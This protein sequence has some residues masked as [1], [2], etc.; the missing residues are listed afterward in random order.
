MW[1][2]DDITLA[3]WIF[4]TSL[5]DTTVGV[6][7]KFAEL[8]TDDNELQDEEQDIARVFAQTRWQWRKGHYLG[9]LATH[10][11]GYGDQAEQYAARGQSLDGSFTDSLTWAA[12]Q[13]D[14][15]YF[16][17]HSHDGFQYFASVAAVHG[18]D[19]I[20]DTGPGTSSGLSDQERDVAGWAADLGARAQLVDTPRWVVGAHGAIASGGGGPGESDAYQQ[21]SLESNRSRFT[22]TRSQVQR[23]GEAIQPEWSNLKVLTL[24]TALSDRDTWDANLLYHRY[25]VNDQGGTVRSDSSRI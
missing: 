5:L 4:D 17:W 2:D 9:F 16:D 13:A 18:T 3:R 21:T 23:F 7:Q 19:I 8:R 12:I 6:A 11:Q 15:N 10:G 1:W 24:Y 20:I 14:R 22:G 25:W